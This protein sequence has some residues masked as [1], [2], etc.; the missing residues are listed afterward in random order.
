[1]KWDAAWGEFSSN[2]KELPLRGAIPLTRVLR[3]GSFGAM[4][5][6][7]VSSADDRRL[8]ISSRREWRES[9]LGSLGEDGSAGSVDIR[10][11]R[12]ARR[13]RWW[14]LSLRGEGDPVWGIARWGGG[15]AGGW[16]VIDAHV[17]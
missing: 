7:S 11:E 14:S 1:M 2:I 17:G 3:L 4:K 8:L 15:G 6:F 16:L 10:I 5:A 9:W 12:D 13:R